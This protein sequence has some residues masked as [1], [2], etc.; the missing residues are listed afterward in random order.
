MTVADLAGRLPGTK[1]SGA[2]WRAPC[3]AHGSKGPTLAIR[4]G[5]DGRLLLKCHARCE[6]ADVL[7]AIGLKISDIMG[8]AENEWRRPIAPK[9]PPT[10]DD[11]REALRIAAATYRMDHRLSTAERLVAADV[12]AIRRTIAARLGIS[13]PPI[14][15]RCSDSAAG[16]RERD[17]LWP[18]L[19]ERAWREVWICRDGREP[20][21]PIEG[22]PAHG[23]L[24]YELL[25]AAEVLA[26]SHLRS[27]A[28]A[29]V[30]ELRRAS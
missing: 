18:V 23:P 28:L 16:G 8:S 27:I 25:E 1:R 7:A 22:F 17:E 11:I 5:R 24:G 6:I 9:S 12:N 13:L 10:R 19:L 20:C 2:G 3:P 29:P 4:E 14:E 15:R 26:A 21:C 30:R